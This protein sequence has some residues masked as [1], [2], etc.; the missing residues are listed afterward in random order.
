MHEQEPEMQITHA[1]DRPAMHG[2]AQFFTGDVTMN[3]LFG[4]A[5][6]SNAHA[7]QL[8]FAPG[9]RSV[10][11]THPAGQR[12]IVTSG[13]GW[14]QQWGGAR[15]QINAG[16]VVWTPAGVKHWHGATSSTPMTHI[17]VQD[18][19]DGRFVDW[20]EQVSDEDYLG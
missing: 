9:A 19:V 12:L 15:E 16:D 7:G 17:A 3:P 4:P 8:T 11:H 5:G 20:L 14:V 18:E 13:T 6:D 10:W 2:P 1:G